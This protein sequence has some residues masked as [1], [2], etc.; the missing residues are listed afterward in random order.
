MSLGR[1]ML[2]TVPIASG[3]LASTTANGTA[4][5]VFARARS[6]LV[7]QVSVPQG[8]HEDAETAVAEPWPSS[9]GTVRVKR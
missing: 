7:V 9:P 3:G 1:I 2:V 8:Q 6:R 5:R 4:L